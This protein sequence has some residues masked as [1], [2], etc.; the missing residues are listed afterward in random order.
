MITD[1]LET[2]VH[3]GRLLH[4]YVTS[5]SSRNTLW[6]TH[7]TMRIL[8][9]KYVS[10]IKLRF[11]LSESLSLAKILDSLVVYVDLCV[12]VSKSGMRAHRRSTAANRRRL[13][14]VGVVE[15]VL[16]NL[17]RRGL[18]CREEVRPSGARAWREVLHR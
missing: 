4:Y 12:V 13:G 17:R 8:F 15:R 6:E 2:V 7:G 10:L 3:R 5:G 16:K 11:N 1:L 14:R 9:I 18:D